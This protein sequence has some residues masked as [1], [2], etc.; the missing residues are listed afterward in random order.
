MKDRETLVVKTRKYQTD[1]GFNPDSTLYKSFNKPEP[2]LL[3]PYIRNYMSP[4]FKV[5]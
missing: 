1:L 4:Y 5:T 3:I 2:L